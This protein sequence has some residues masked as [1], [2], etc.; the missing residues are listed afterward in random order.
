MDCHVRIFQFEDTTELFG[1]IVASEH[2]RNAVCETVRYIPIQHRE[3]MKG[4][5]REEW[6]ATH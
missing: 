4:D 2:N 6:A 5:I 3:K 1:K